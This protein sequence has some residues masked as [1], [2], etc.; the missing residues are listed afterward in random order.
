MGQYLGV[1]FGNKDRKITVGDQP[2]QKLSETI[3]QRTS[4]AWWLM[5]V[6]P[7]TRKQM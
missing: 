2:Q 6:I 7:S 1:K 4:W 5:S 3:S